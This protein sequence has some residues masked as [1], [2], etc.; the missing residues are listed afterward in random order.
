M[1]SSVVSFASL[2]SVTARISR[3]VSINNFSL[4]I[5]VFNVNEMLKPLK[6]YHAMGTKYGKKLLHFLSKLTNLSVAFCCLARA[7]HNSALQLCPD[8]FT[9]AHF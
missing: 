6:E 7:E 5:R 3:L 2:V 8:S 1:S 9:F 4:I